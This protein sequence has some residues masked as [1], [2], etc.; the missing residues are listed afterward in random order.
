MGMTPTTPTIA[1][2]YA[3]QSKLEDIATEG[4]EKRYA[5]HTRLNRIVRDWGYAK[6][7]KLLPDE[8]FGSV[9]L[10]CF[11]NTRGLDLVALNQLLK[12][13]HQLVIDGGYGKLKGR[14]FRLSNMGD[15]TDATITGL[16]A[17]LD[18][19]IA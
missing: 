16:L 3:L 9:T 8:R 14:T 5:R 2:I 4:L 7:F 15:E 1:H 13:K 17:A 12:T 19:E 18:A 10:N 6:G 11:E